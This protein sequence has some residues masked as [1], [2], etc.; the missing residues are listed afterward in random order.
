M[1]VPQFPKKY[2]LPG[3]FS[4]RAILDR[5]PRLAGLAIPEG[6]VLCFQRPLL[7]HLTGNRR[8]Q[9]LPI[10]HGK[11]HIV[12][13]RSVRIAVLGGFGIGAPSAVFALELAAALGSRRIVAAGLAGGLDEGMRAGDLVVCRRALRDEGT[14]HHYL[15]TAAFA[16]ADPT[17]TARL[18][19]SLAHLGYAHEIGESWTTDAPLRE[20]MAEI[21]HYRRRGLRTVEMEAAALFAAAQSLGLACTAAFAISDA[22]KG[23]H[24]QLDFDR[25]ALQRGLRRLGDAALHAL[26][27]PNP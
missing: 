2:G 21:E 7:E 6:L 24:W 9:A 8:T 3:V 26:A 19:A 5:D 11:L 27:P 14:S 23:G 25:S 16:D 22:P 18:V 20:T 17:L 13:T 10:P 15:P 4:A 1:S 12:E